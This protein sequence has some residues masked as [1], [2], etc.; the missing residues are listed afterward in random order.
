MVKAVLD[1]CVLVP[2]PLYDT[3]L[4]LAEAGL[5][6]PA[7]SEQI[8]EETLRALITKLGIAPASA[9][10]RITLMKKAFD[11]AMAQGFEETIPL[12]TNDPKDRH[13]LAAAVHYGA[14]VIVTANTAD[15]PEPSTSPYEIEVIHP[16]DFLLNLLN[17]QPR[18]VINIL[19]EQ[20]N[21]YTNPPFEISEF[22][23]TFMPTVPRFAH[24]ADALEAKY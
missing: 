4:R 18:T 14:S 24:A 20:R 21:D 17:Q 5:F 8:L 13:V 12:M 15:F 10:R 16:D 19:R 2:Y 6:V 3:L 1:A 22:Y 9:N 11:G 7:W 23:S